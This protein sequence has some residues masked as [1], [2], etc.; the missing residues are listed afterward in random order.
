[1]IVGVY[2][3]DLIITGGDANT[4]TKFKK[5]M[6]S[7]FKMSDLGLLSYYLGLEVT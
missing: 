2:V 5:Q 6:L 4:V 1:M 7:T 3:D